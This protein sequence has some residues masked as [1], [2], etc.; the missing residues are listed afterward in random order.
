M[1]GAQQKLRQAA[2]ILLQ[3]LFVERDAGQAQKIILEII[4]IPGDRLAIETRSRIADLVI[5]IP[6]R[7]HLKTRQRG[8]RFAV[9]FLGLRIDHRASAV[10]PEKLEERGVAQV[11]FEVSALAQI[12][13]INLRNRQSV[14]AKM[15]REFK[16]SHILLPHGIKNANGARPPAGEAHNGPPRTAQFALKRL[17]DFGRQPVML[18]EEFFQYVHESLSRIRASCFPTIPTPANPAQA[19]TPAFADERK[20]TGRQRRAPRISPLRLAPS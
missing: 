20:V 7:L 16:E 15:P 18:F 12:L 4:Q 5:Q 3:R 2:E 10:L 11:L 13:P 14:P 1:V 17:H 6:A 8:H 19:A 9:R